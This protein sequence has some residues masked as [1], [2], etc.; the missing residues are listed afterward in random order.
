M[1]IV[2][3]TVFTAYAND[4]DKA[5]THASEA[6]SYFK[7][8]YE[9]SSLEE[10]QAYAK[11]GMIEASSAEYK[12]KWECGCDEAKQAAVMAYLHGQTAHKCSNSLSE[13]KDHLKKAMDSASEITTKLKKCGK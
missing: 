9:A 10:A 11:K 2:T 8:A 13:A 7:K 12:S 4:C 1:S 6:Y 5:K 3:L